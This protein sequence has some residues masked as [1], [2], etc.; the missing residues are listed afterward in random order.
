M[1]PKH[2]TLHMNTVERQWETKVMKPKTEVTQ[3]KT[4]ER[5]RKPQRVT[6]PCDTVMPV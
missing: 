2:R 4:M 5:V 3:K 1:V 6:S